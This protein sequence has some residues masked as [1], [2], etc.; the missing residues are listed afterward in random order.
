[1]M[2]QLAVLVGAQQGAFRSRLINNFERSAPLSYES[3]SP[4]RLAQ[5]ISSQ[6]AAKMFAPPGGTR[7]SGLCPQRTC[8]KTWTLQRESAA[9]TAQ[10]SARPSLPSPTLELHPKQVDAR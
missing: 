9:E 3:R 5:Q 7:L 6:R 10:E 8:S 2:N 4:H 1:M